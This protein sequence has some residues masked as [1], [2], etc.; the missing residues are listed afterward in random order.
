PSLAVQVETRPCWASPP[1][2]LIVHTVAP[3]GGLARASTSGCAPAGAAARQPSKINA[4]RIILRPLYAVYGRHYLMAPR[5]RSMRAPSRRRA[6]E[7]KGPD[8]DSRKTG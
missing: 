5:R 7:S 2:E 4:L 3:A 1:L 8:R 6:D